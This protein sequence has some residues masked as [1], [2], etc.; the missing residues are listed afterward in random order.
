MSRFKTFGI[1][2]ALLAMVMHQPGLAA[3]EREKEVNL[4][5]AKSGGALF[6]GSHIPS[7]LP[8]QRQRRKSAAQNR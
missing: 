6:G 7:R 4:L 5:N 2:Q 3:K 1:F 8:N